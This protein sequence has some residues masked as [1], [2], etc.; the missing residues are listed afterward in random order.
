[1]GR[2]L[3]AYWVPSQL[4]FRGIFRPESAGTTREF[5]YSNT[6]PALKYLVSGGGFLILLVAHLEI[7]GKTMSCPR[8]NAPD[9]RAILHDVHFIS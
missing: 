6:W 3:R 2:I 9:S 5:G 4:F 1:M 8:N 7:L